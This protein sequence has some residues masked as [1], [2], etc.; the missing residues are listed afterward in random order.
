MK[1]KMMKM[2]TCAFLIAASAAVGGEPATYDAGGVAMEGYFAAAQGSAATV[3]ILPTWKG[4]SDYEKDRADM[5]ASTGWNAFVGDLHGAGKLPKSMAE[6]AGAH[7]AFFAEEDRMS[8]ILRAAVET[9]DRLGGGEIVVLGYSMGGGAAMELARSGLGNALGVDGYAV[10]SGRVTDPKG[11]MVP[12]GSGAI[13]V[14]HGETDGRVPV[15]G[16]V[17]FEDDMSFT[18]VPVEIHIYPGQGH[19]FSAFGF[20][21]YDAEA[22]KQSWAAFLRFLERISALDG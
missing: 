5:L 8:G 13:F 6:M 9:A 14:A 2:M 19:L 17:T 18:D 11:R 12:D 10:F 3:V 4:I 7:D 21:N 16:L 1:M 22:D 20:P 15:S